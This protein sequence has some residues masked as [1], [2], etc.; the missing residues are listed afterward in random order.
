MTLRQRFSRW[1]ADGKAFCQLFGL[2]VVSAEDDAGK[3]MALANYRVYT[4]LL[5]EQ[6]DAAR[7]SEA[8]AVVERRVER[9]QLG[10]DLDELCGERDNWREAAEGR[11]AALKVLLAAVRQR[12]FCRVCGDTLDRCPDVCACRAAYESLAPVA[13]EACVG[14]A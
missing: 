13:G 7:R 14:E 5:T 8:R 1:I 11:A 3:D 10:A 2:L 4:A 6:R 12:G 9:A